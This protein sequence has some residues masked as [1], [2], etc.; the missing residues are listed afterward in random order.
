MVVREIDY[1]NWLAR[2]YMPAHQH[3][4]P[5]RRV[6]HGHNQTKFGI[7]F[8]FFELRQPQLGQNT[9][10]RHY[11]GPK[12]SLATRWCDGHTPTQPFVVFFANSRVAAAATRPKAD[13]R[14]QCRGAKAP[15]PP[16]AHMIMAGDGPNVRLTRE[17]V[18]PVLIEHKPLAS[19]LR[20]CDSVSTQKWDGR[21]ERLTEKISPV[22]RVCCL[23]GRKRESLDLNAVA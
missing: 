12:H 22:K 15:S 11:R 13:L 18:I 21:S 20:A 2:G 16:R 3:C 6:P 4:A 7:I 14:H 23:C 1:G 8:I 19:T 9:H 10:L 5:S 17:H